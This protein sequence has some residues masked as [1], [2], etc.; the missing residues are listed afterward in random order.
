MKLNIQRLLFPAIALMLM[1]TACNEENDLGTPPRLFRPV[2]EGSMGGTWIKLTWDRYTGTQSYN[3]QLSDDT[4]F[5]NIL[6]NASTEDV[7]YT[8]E[9][10]RYNTQYYIRIQGIGDGIQSEPVT[11]TGK[12]AKYPTHLLSPASSDCIDTQVRVKWETEYYDNLKVYIG[13]EYIKTVDLT[14]EDNDEKTIIVRDLNPSSTYTIQAYREEAYLGEMDYTTVAAQVIEGDY[15]DLR[16]LDPAEAYSK[17][18]Q[19][20]FDELEAQYPGGFTVILDGGI[21]YEIGTVNFSTNFSLVTGLSLAGNAIIEH[22]G[23]IGIKAD[24]NVGFITLNNLIFT[25]HPSSPRNGGN[26]GGKYAIDIRGTTANAKIGELNIVGCD[27]RYKR[28]MFRAQSPVEIGKITIDN[29]IIDSM[30]GYGIT[31]ADHANAYF[32]E[33]IIKNSTIAHAEK[34]LVASKPT[35]TDQC[36]SIVLENLTVCY[37]PKGEGNYMID[38]N[39]QTLP[40]GITVKNCIFGI[41]W[42]SKVRGMRSAT[43]NIAIDN[44]FRAGDLEWTVNASTGEPQNPIDL[45][46]LTETTAALFADPQNLN[47]KITHD[48]LVNKVGDP[49]W[50]K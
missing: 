15:A 41:G 43:T 27:I 7:E 38:Y 28:G 1:V 29:C 33:V 37:A 23:G 50:W 9:G 22:N 18:T 2:V 16:S 10:L 6:E 4:D 17:L 34:I 46:R 39:N 24:A 12:T 8:F 36:H 13:K 19:T 26:F 14:A 5:T 30:G 42:D 45:E 40:G 21:H 35:P 25:D 47:F 3:I 32:K 31:N 48:A 49:R 11:Y 20:Y 44:S